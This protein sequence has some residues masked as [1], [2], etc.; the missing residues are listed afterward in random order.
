M[1]GLGRRKWRVAGSF[2]LFEGLMPI[3]GFFLGRAA[4]TVLGSVASY[5]GVALL[6]VVA[7]WMIVEGIMGDETASGDVAGGFGLVLISLSVSMD[8]LAIGFSLGIL[9][10]SI[11][12]AVPLIAAQ[13]FVITLVGIRIGGALGRRVASWAELMAG[14]VLAFVGIALLFRLLY[15]V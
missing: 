5:V 3:A 7:G 4:G 9:G 2:A 6:L 11:Y 8:E 12:V 10:A 13:A 1:A 14:A 15:S